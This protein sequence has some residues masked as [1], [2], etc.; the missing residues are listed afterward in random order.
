M[1]TQQTH[2]M[3]FTPDVVIKHYVDWA[4]GEAER[5]W[6]G[7][8]T[9]ARLAPGLSPEPVERGMLTD[10]PFV[11]MTRLPGRPLGA[12]PLSTAQI[13]AVV[14][15][16]HALFALPVP[17]RTPE[18]WMG[19][20]SAHDS[21]RRSL[22]PRVDLP[23]TL[24]GAELIAT[25][26]TRSRDWLDGVAVVGGPHD[27]VLARGDGNL[28]NLLWDGTRCRMVDFEEFGVSDQC[29]ELADLVEHASG[30]L[31]GLLDVEAFLSGF[32]L[33]PSARRRLHRYRTTFAI[34]W[35]VMLLPGHRG[36]DRNPTGSTRRQAEHTLRLLECD[37]G[38]HRAG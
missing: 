25:A 6:T 15:A 37:L 3:R 20:A 5:E 27:P 7:L 24:P 36:F 16:T 10:A 32:D 28:A 18:R 19:P 13:D 2:R 11:V 21:V 4:R 30:R 34:F 35:L 26:L 38:S 33:E 9:I 17:A 31:A 29:F 8:T 22:E 23:C 12:E 1:R 14:S